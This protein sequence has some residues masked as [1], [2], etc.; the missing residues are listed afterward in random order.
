[1]G[2][3]KAYAAGEEEDEGRNGGLGRQECDERRHEEQ[4]ANDSGLSPE[5]DV[6]QFPH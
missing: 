4:G 3:G 6:D 5:S 1:M 2:Q